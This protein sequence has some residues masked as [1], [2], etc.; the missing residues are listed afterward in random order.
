MSRSVTRSSFSPDSTFPRTRL[1]H[2]KLTLYGNEIAEL[3]GMLLLWIHDPDQAFQ[4]E[5]IEVTYDFGP[6][7][8][9]DYIP[10]GL[11]LVLDLDRVLTSHSAG[12]EK[13][14]AGIRRLSFDFLSELG[15]FTAQE[16]HDTIVAL[17]PA[18]ASRQPQILCVSV[19]QR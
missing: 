7:M 6:R 9:L 1:E 4:F 15:E 17:W 14:I 12:S 2:L 3:R 13:A 8:T 19:R 16:W 18:T 10:N 11:S 5:V